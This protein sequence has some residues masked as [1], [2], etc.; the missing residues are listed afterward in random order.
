MSAIALT[1][2]HA[3]LSSIGRL[4]KANLIKVRDAKLPA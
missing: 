3:S 4:K 2:L 1:S